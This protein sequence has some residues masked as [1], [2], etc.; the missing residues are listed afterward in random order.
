MFIVGA[1]LWFG[2]C[3]LLG[4]EDKEKDPV[5]ELEPGSRNYTWS[6]DSVYSAPGGWMNTIWGSSPDNVC[7][8]SSGGFDKLW[9]YDGIEWAPYPYREGPTGFSGDFYS[10]FGFGQ[11][12]VW[13]GGKRPGGNSIWHYNG[14]DWKLFYI[15]Q[16][17]GKGEATVLDI[18][19]CT[20]SNL[21][22]VGTVPTGQSNPTY[23]GFILHY[24]GRQWREVLMTDFGMQFQR[25]RE[26]E[27]QIYLS[28][29]GPYSTQLI[30]DSVSI[31]RLNDNILTTL[32]SKSLSEAGVVNLNNFDGKIY[33][34]VDNEITDINFNSVL[35]FSISGE[36][37]SVHGRHEKD[38]FI[39]TDSGVLHYNG[40]DTQ[41]LFDD[42]VQPNSLLLENDVFFFANDYKAG[43]N[44]IYHGTLN[45][46]K[47]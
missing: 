39:A 10:I 33:L 24:D 45:K 36:I 37:Y 25:I 47:E 40:E 14:R 41:L 2:A 31:Y 43:T 23:Q 30:S 46:E 28:G 13:M 27:E 26:N 15:Y 44:L 4:L 7:I 20:S 38:M 42:I 32:Y 8:A 21:Y 9:H 11:D 17:D 5:V 18:W 35:P 19:G 6:V 1:Y 12:D 16:P 22:A 29:S 3:G 34:V